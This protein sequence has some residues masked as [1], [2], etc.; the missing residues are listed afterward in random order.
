MEKWKH[1]KIFKSL[2]S[3]IF[4]M[5]LNFLCEAEF[6]LS[7]L[8][9]HTTY[10]SAKKYFNSLN[11]N[12]TK[13]IW[14]LQTITP[15]NFDCFVLKNS[16]SK[17]NILERNHFWTKKTTPHSYICHWNET[18]QVFRLFRLFE[19]IFTSERKSGN[20]RNF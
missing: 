19:F 4:F 2:K 1:R 20:F 6:S 7:I 8:Y 11:P 10:I 5:K 13:I 18:F 3:L 9:L 14:F 15:L 12:N 16:V 17:F